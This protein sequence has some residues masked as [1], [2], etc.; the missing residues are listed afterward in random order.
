MVE[1]KDKG[2][3]AERDAL[4]ADIHRHFADVTRVGGVSWSESEVIDDWGSEEDCATARA[5]DTEA[6]WTE[7][8]DDPE[9]STWTGFGGFSFLD[10]IGFRYYAAAAMVRC[11]STIED[12]GVLFH[13]DRPRSDK[14]AKQQLAKFTPVQS[15]CVARFLDFMARAVESTFSRDDADFAGWRA[16]LESRWIEFLPKS[17]GGRE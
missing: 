6:S 8:V 17:G 11:L 13:L 9:W 7:L 2:L 5:R 1:L 12:C 15:V 10:G 16:A 3:S 14:L 4:I